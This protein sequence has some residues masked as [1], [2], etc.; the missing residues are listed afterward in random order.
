MFVGDYVF[1]FQFVF[2]CVYYYNYYTKTLTELQTD[3]T[4]FFTKQL[5]HYEQNTRHRAQIRKIHVTVHHKTKRCNNL[6]QHH[7]FFFYSNKKTRIEVSINNL[8]SH[9]TSVKLMQL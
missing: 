9:I 8:R 4:G 7:T 6:Q 1:A 2:Y 5:C 3:S